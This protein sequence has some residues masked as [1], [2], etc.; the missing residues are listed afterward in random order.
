VLGCFAN[1]DKKL[2]TS[3]GGQISF[4]AVICD[5]GAAHQFHDEIAG[6]LV[7]RKQEF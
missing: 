1:L 7:R 4:I 2:E 3:L 5:F 6:A